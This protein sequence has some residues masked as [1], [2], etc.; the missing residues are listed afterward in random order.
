VIVTD[1]LRRLTGDHVV[2]SAVAVRP[3]AD[4]PVAVDELVFERIALVT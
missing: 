1:A 4:G 2:I 3:S